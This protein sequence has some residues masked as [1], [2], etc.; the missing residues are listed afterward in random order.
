MTAASARESA[1]WAGILR[2][3]VEAHNQAA[4]SMAWNDTAWSPSPNDVLSTETDVLGGRGIWLEKK[5]EGLG[6]AQKRYFKL[7]QDSTTRDLHFVYFESLSKGTPAGRKGFV[8]ITH[9]ST[10]SVNGAIMLIANTDR[11]W[12]L[13]APSEEEAATWGELLNSTRARLMPNDGAAFASSGA[14][15]PSSSRLGATSSSGT[16]G[17]GGGDGGGGGGG[18]DDDAM[19]VQDDDGDDTDESLWGGHGLWLTKKGEGVG[20]DRRRYFTL[21]MGRQSRVIHLNYYANVR[22]G[23]PVDRKG[24]ILIDDSS[25]IMSDSSQVIIANSDRTWNLTAS[26][27]TEAD[28]LCRSLKDALS[29]R[30]EAEHNADTAVSL[31]ASLFPALAE[32]T[33]TD[34][35]MDDEDEDDV[36][37]GQG[38][39]LL[40]KG[41][42]MGALTGDKRRFFTVTHGKTSHLLKFNY[43]ANVDKEGRPFNKRGFIPLIA[44]SSVIPSGKQILVNNV[45]RTW[46]LTAATVEEA[47][48]WTQLL[49]RAIAAQAA[50]SPGAGAGL[51]GTA[52]ERAAGAGA[53]DDDED[54]AAGG[55]GAGAGA[56]N[57]LA[58]EDEENLLPGVGIWLVKKGEGMGRDRR[59]YFSLFK[60]RTSRALKF[61]YF[62]DVK[63]GIP[64]ERKGHI[65]LDPSSV[66]S[67]KGPLITIAQS[68]RDWKLTAPDAEAA[69]SWART[70]Q[71]ALKNQAQA[72]PE[73]T[74]LASDSLFTEEAAMNEADQPLLPGV[75]LSKKGEG[76]TTGEK[77]RFFVMVFGQQSRMIKWNYYAAVEDGVPDNKKGF[78]PVHTRSEITAQDKHIVIRNPDRTWPVTASTYEEAEYWATLL[79]KAVKEQNMAAAEKMPLLAY[80]A[81]M[82]AA[83]ESP[84]AIS[85]KLGEVYGADV[86]SS[87]TGVLQRASAAASNMARG[88]ADGADESEAG[89]GND[90]DD[91]EDVLK[92]RGVWLAKKG[93]GL[94]V[95]TG[96]K[97]RYFL[98]VRGAFT[99]T[100]HW[101]YYVDVADGVPSN[102]KGSV[103]VLPTSLISAKGK[104]IVIENQDRTWQLAAASPE[105]ASEWATLL[106]QQK[107]AAYPDGQLPVD[108]GDFVPLPGFNVWLQKKGEGLGAVTGVKTRLFVLM[109]SAATN[110]LRLDYYANEKDGQPQDKKGCIALD[111][112]AEVSTEG[113]VLRITT[114]HRVWQLTAASPDEATRLAT[115]L[116]ENIRDKLGQGNLETLPGF[117]L[118]LQKK[119]EGLGAAT[120]EKARFFVLKKNLATNTLQLDYFAD[121]NAG[122]PVNRKG[123]IPVLDDSEVEAEDIHLLIVS[124]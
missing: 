18:D 84:A 32:E 30:L 123:S 115:V 90:E 20:R 76:L 117:D 51:S 79:R 39:W 66:V 70:L 102:K 110:A 58:F 42:G 37:P 7:Y 52:T 21:T 27:A 101:N 24:F 112:E 9:A 10:I 78:I 73:T 103:P 4:K 26:S 63:N 54:A 13:T 12:Q 61:A 122:E 22:S 95:L 43:F 56:G 44:G 93:E 113:K 60:G 19:A 41:E 81:K 55:A 69:A 8:P 34:L 96:D 106:E 40:K 100:L 94:G 17:A 65:M 97:K 62:A 25:N 53:G 116:R 89:P 67:A 104:V 82:T 71:Q 48:A 118:W 28:Q 88:A 120:G 36:L 72:L 74:N 105:E 109:H 23:E 99:K 68:S 5:G 50:K 98:L 108:Q 124:V 75:W 119:G 92:G 46:H 35:M 91:I 121:I 87:Y 31:A 3:A 29:R 2:R 83:G 77:R 107:R 14:R 114:G 45:D 64:I 111:P 11:T 59:R 80:H 6:R 38:V 86:L 16:P 33:E 47:Q 1:E 57:G 15:A 85:A 49:Q